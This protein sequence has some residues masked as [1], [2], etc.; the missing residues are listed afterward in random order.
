MTNTGNRKGKN[1]KMDCSKSRMR[2]YYDSWNLNQKIGKPKNKGSFLWAGIS[3]QVFNNIAN[4]SKIVHVTKWRQWHPSWSCN[5]RK[6][7][8]GMWGNW[9]NSE[10]IR[11]FFGTSNRDRENDQK[12][13]FEVNRARRAKS[14]AWKRQNFEK[15][16]KSSRR[17]SCEFLDASIFFQ[18]TLCFDGRHVKTRAWPRWEAD[19]PTS[20]QEESDNV[21]F[22]VIAFSDV[23]F[24]SFV[25]PCSDSTPKVRL[26][27]VVFENFTIILSLITTN[28]DM[29]RTNNWHHIDGPITDTII[30][31]CQLTYYSVVHHN[32]SS[33]TP[34]F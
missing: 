32:K 34:A 24:S 15:S 3:S 26:T 8:P 25:S 17:I 13:M 31:V 16:F 12:R 22:A 10:I 14:V 30:D 7:W 2:D 11:R 27:R 18:R 21:P 23:F 1:W 29:W 5:T 28:V 4:L 6:C 20:A 19:R 9:C 33:N